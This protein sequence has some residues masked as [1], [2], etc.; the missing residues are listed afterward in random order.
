MGSLG[1]NRCEWPLLHEEAEE[2]CMQKAV[3]PILLKHTSGNRA[4]QRERSG[5]GRSEKAAF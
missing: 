2:A 4:G 3:L 1:P 5:S